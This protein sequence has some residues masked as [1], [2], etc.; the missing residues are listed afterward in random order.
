MTHQTIID[1][2]ENVVLQALDEITGTYDRPVSP[3]YIADVLGIEKSYV[4]TALK[5]LKVNQFVIYTQ[6]LF[7]E[8]MLLCVSGYQITGPGRQH[9]LGRLVV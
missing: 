4:K 3:V 7:T 9:L 5:Q 1:D 2:L 8:D 6:G